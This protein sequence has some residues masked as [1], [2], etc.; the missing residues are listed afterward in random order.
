MTLRNLGAIRLCYLTFLIKISFKDKITGKDGQLLQMVNPET[1]AN[2][3]G[4]HWSII[5]DT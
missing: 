1:S 3:E 5:T 4:Q 2:H